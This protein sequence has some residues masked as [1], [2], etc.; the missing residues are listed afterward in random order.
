MYDVI[1]RIEKKE[2]SQ[3]E[4]NKVHSIL[5]NTEVKGC[6]FYSVASLDNCSFIRIGIFANVGT[7]EAAEEKAFELMNKIG[8]TI[9][10]FDSVTE[11]PL[12]GRPAPTF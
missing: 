2:S 10:T 8:Y 4:T 6:S 9:H 11:K 12:Y 5:M 3:R 7:T 1:F